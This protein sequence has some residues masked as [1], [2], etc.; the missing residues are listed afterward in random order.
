MEGRASAQTST[1]D[2]GSAKEGGEQHSIVGRA[3]L[4]DLTEGGSNTG[5]GE[6]AERPA[7]PRDDFFYRRKWKATG[8]HTRK[9]TGG[10]HRNALRHRGSWRPPRR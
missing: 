4:F 9:C 8:E 6:T 3:Q 1:I 7:G 2:S 5:E 10:G